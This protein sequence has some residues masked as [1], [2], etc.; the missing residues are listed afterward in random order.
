MD[1]YY[2]TLTFKVT[3]RE[4]GS[5]VATGNELPIIFAARTVAHLKRKTRD[6]EE[7]VRRFL[8]TMSP[9]EQADF[10]KSRSVD[11]EPVGDVAEQLSIP[12]L[13]NA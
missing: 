8:S 2:V 1:S 4:D 13:V 9:G 3:H 7:S 12:V 10:W 11:Q 6:V 5:V